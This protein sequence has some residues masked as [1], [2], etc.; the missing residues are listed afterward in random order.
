MSNTPL[1][2]TFLTLLF[3]DSE[4]VNAYTSELDAALDNYES[5]LAFTKNAK[6]IRDVLVLNTGFTLPMQIEVDT[7]EA[8]LELQPHDSYVLDEY[9]VFIEAFIPEW[10]SYARKLKRD[11]K[12]YKGT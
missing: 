10:K 9:A 5:A 2:D 4:C 8:Y 11:A 1:V 12:R 6:E 7:Y 3:I